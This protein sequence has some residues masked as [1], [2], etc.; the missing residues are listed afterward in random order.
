MFINKNNWELLNP[1]LHKKTG[2]NS[3][4]RD[5]I[6]A[7]LPIVIYS[8]YCYGIKALISIFLS[9]FFA[10]LTEYLWQKSFKKAV[11]IEDLSSVITA[12]ILVLMLPPYFVWW[13]II[14][15][16]IFS[17]VFGKQIFGGLG[18]NLINPAVTG[19]IFLQI[20]FPKQAGEIFFKILNI[21]N[22]PQALSL[23]YLSHNILAGSLLTKMQNNSLIEASIITLLLGAIYL[24]VRN[25]IAISISISYLSILLI[26]Y[27]VS[28]IISGKISIS[29]IFGPVSLFS[30]FFL[31]SDPVTTPISLKGKIVFGIGCGILSLLAYA[32]TGVIYVF[33]ISIILMNILVPFIDYSTIPKPLGIY[34]KNQKLW[35]S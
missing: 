14:I 20:I 28:V 10:V 4:M 35:K 21:F 33:Y 2:I 9:V 30:I 32:V 19:W 15:G 7:L 12:V 1:F 25:R 27:V 29:N 31:A 22:A 24:I 23:K 8:I 18:N 13:G 11:R 34:A 16:A 26:G 3:I 17:I 5:V 6:I